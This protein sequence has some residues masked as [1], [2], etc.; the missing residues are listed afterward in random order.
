MGREADWQ[1]HAARTPSCRHVGSSHVHSKYVCVCM[2]VCCVTQVTDGSG[3][4]L[5]VAN[6][7]HSEWGKI[8]ASVNEEGDDQTPLQ[9]RTRVCVCV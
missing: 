4:I 5:I 1:L 7:E 3:K 8:L 6:G 2:C 9:V